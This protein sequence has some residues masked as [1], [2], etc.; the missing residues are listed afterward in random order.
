MQDK[1][2]TDLEVGDTVALAADSSSQFVIDAFDGDLVVCKSPPPADAGFNFP[3]DP[4]YQ[5]PRPYAPD[6]ARVNFVPTDLVKV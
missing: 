2:G 3:S 4:D 6:L 5:P 1:N